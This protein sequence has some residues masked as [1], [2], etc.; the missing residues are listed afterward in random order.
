MKTITAFITYCQ[1]V[2][3]EVVN[4]SILN[5]WETRH[6]VQFIRCFRIRWLLNN[7]SQQSDC[8]KKHCVKM[9]VN[10]CL[11][12]WHQETFLTH[13][14]DIK[15]T[16]FYNQISN[17]EQLNSWRT[18][19]KTDWRKWRI[20]RKNQSTW[21]D[22]A[23]KSEK[24]CSRHQRDIEFNQRIQWKASLNYS[25]KRLNRRNHWENQKIFADLVNFF[26]KNLCSELTFQ[27]KTS[28]YLSIKNQ[29][30][31]ETKWYE[32]SHL[33]I[34]K[35]NIQR[36]SCRKCLFETLCRLEE[37]QQRREPIEWS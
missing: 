19:F 23:T 15:K 29:K 20:E 17:N 10:D 30:M 31:E 27:R 22:C 4:Q 8:Q 12:H 16:L 3:T 32:Y 26:R 14:N 1:K 33:R 18:S 9:C 28:K 13:T 24:W 37:D 35:H 11:K 36:E 6:I 7:L 34:C 25:T 21:K 5:C 2:S